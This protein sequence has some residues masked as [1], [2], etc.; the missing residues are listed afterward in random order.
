MT[1]KTPP[2]GRSPEDALRSLSHEVHRLRRDA[3]H[4]KLLV[5]SLFVV[6]ALLVSGA[7]KMYF[8]LETRLDDKVT[9]VNERID[10]A[11]VRRPGGGQIDVVKDILGPLQSFMGSGGQ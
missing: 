10:E 11:L 6:L 9:K 7:W 3:A 5:Y 8:H 2:S 1:D 4:L